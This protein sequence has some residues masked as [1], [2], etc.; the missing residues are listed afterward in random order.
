MRSGREW[1][2]RREGRI[3]IK[4]RRKKGKK[5]TRERRKSERRKKGRQN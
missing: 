5:Y 3:R 2:G 1:E 4:G